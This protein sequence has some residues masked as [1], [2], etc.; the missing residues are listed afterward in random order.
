VIPSEA[1]LRVQNRYEW[2]YVARSA[3]SLG[4][5]V[6]DSPLEPVVSAKIG[7]KTRSQSFVR[8]VLVDDVDP[9][10]RLRKKFADSR[11]SLYG[12]LI[13]AIGDDCGCD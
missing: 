1:F 4:H 2:N 13:E 10:T 3:L 6:A 9:V 8:R 12:R 11:A 5:K 7:Y